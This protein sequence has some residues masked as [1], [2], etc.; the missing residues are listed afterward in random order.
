M[1]YSRFIQ[2]YKEASGWRKL[3]H[4]TRHRQN[5]LLWQQSAA[6]PRAHKGSLRQYPERKS[7]LLIRPQRQRIFDWKH[8]RDHWCPRHIDQFQDILTSR[9][10]SVHIFIYIY[11]YSFLNIFLLHCIHL[12]HTIGWPQHSVFNSLSLKVVLIIIL[13]IALFVS[14]FCF[15]VFFL[16]SCYFGFSRHKHATLYFII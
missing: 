15:F 11:I 4:H 13:K 12:C 3:R 9:L 14:L 7:A 6:I 5:V 16:W 2:S 8:A 1:R 10:N